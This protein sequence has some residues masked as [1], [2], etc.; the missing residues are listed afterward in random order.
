MSL[1]RI[2][3]EVI[4]ASALLALALGALPLL[5]RAPAAARRLVLAVAL[6]GVLALPLLSAALP[7]WSVGPARPPIFAARDPLAV[8]VGS[9][10]SPVAAASGSASI[11]ATATAP[12]A[13]HV[14]PTTLLLAA[15]A[16]G[17]TL[18]L[19]RLAA[20][21]RLARGIARRA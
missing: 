8:D 9:S 12:R 18:V 20:G 14:D 16:L 4:R 3:G 1:D 7:S 17:A 21:L 6:G 19:V 15:W 10:E 5:R 11:T 13:H 2:L